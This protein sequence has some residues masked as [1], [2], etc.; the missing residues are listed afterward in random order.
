MAVNKRSCFQ[1]QERTAPELEVL[2][3]PFPTT[4]GVSVVLQVLKS[5]VLL[6]APRLAAV[7]N[8]TIETLRRSD[9]VIAKGGYVYRERGGF[10]GLVS[11]WFTMWPFL[12]AKR[13]GATGIVYSASIGPWDRWLSL[14]LSALPLRRADVICPRDPDSAAR[15]ASEIEPKGRVME[16]P[17]C[18]FG[19]LGDQTLVAPHP[20]GDRHRLVIIPRKDEQRPETWVWFR[21]ATRRLIDE[22]PDLVP[23][24]VTQSTTDERAARELADELGIEDEALRVCATPDEAVDVY[25]E[26]MLSFSA[27]MH[28]TILSYMAGANGLLVDFDPG[29][30]SPMFRNLD[31]EWIVVRSGSD[32]DDVVSRATELVRPDAIS[33]I[34]ERVRRVGGE[35]VSHREDLSSFVHSVRPT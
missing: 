12:Y 11:G 20:D 19:L 32:I 31:L 30:S 2:D 33:A 22:F 35:V 17:D 21:Q 15:L 26:T 5:L 8:P 27:R 10:A 24:I 25:L 16:M 6:A 14:R 3:P 28:G 23:T 4:G 18:V 9:Y 29:K 34:A 1:Y 7:D 13:C